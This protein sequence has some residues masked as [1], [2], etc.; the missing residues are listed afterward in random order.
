MIKYV[1]VG[2]KS[3]RDEFTMLILI[4]LTGLRDAWLVSKTSF[5]DVLVRMFFWECIWISRLRKNG[6]HQCAWAMGTI[7]FFLLKT[8][9][10]KTVQM[11]VVFIFC[12]SHDIHHLWISHTGS[13]GS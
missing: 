9:V 6:F 10:R 12:L 1:N 4:Y 5:R 13:S 8:S 11:K 3:T 7:P 2:A